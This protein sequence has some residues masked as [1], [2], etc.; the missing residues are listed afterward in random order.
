MHPWTGQFITGYNVKYIPV[1]DL[2][3]TFFYEITAE[4]G[5]KT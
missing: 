5:I 1:T 4:Q 2:G 3:I